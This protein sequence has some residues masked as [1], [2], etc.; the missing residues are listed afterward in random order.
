MMK[1]LTDYQEHLIEFRPTYKLD[2]NSVIYDSSKKQRVPS[3]CDR[4][5]FQKHPQRPQLQVNCHLYTSRPLTNSD[6]YPVIANF[7]LNI[8][9]HNRHNRETLLR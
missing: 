8:L 5:L 6:H 9:S 2:K 1:V 7:T 3:W 4:I